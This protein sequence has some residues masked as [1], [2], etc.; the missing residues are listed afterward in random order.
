MLLY[1]T[2]MGLKL[3][4]VL[5]PILHDGKIRELRVNELE[6]GVSGLDDP[7]EEEMDAYVEGSITRANLHPFDGGSPRRRLKV[8]QYGQSSFE[9]LILGYDEPEERFVDYGSAKTTFAER[10]QCIQ[11]TRGIKGIALADE[12]STL[13]AYVGRCFPETDM[14][15]DTMVEGS[16]YMRSIVNQNWTGLLGMTW[17]NDPK[18][19]NQETA[20]AYMAY[21]NN[22]E[23]EWQYSCAAI[24]V[25]APSWKAVDNASA[26]RKGDPLDKSSAAETGS[27]VATETNE[28]EEEEDEHFGESK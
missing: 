15:K 20:T 11:L 3:N 10:L 12:R 27:L 2:V 7:E 8:Y 21:G 16:E 23:L 22:A 13:P 4:T 28:K 9:G 24:L 25:V 18:E 5:R 26:K 17:I 1:S 6:N 14:D 19:G